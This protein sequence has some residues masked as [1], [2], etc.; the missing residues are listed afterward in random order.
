MIRTI[1]CNRIDNLLWA[2]G[3][4]E[5][6]HIGQRIQFI[7]PNRFGIQSIGAESKS[8]QHDDSQQG[9]RASAADLPTVCVLF[10]IAL[11]L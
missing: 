9:Q 10:R 4:I 2:I 1:G 7:R 5:N 3:W 8:H 6:T 11:S